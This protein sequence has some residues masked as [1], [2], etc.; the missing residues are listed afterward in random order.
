MHNTVVL[1]ST[2]DKFIL[3][4][5]GFLLLTM[6]YVAIMVVFVYVDSDIL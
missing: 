2:E 6:M 3:L 5:V 1:F 4:Q